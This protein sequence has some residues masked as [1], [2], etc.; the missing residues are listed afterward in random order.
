METPRAL[1][2]HQ[3]LYAQVRDLLLQRAAAGRN[4]FDRAPP[5]EV[6]GV[7][8]LA[9]GVSGLIAG[10]IAGHLGYASLGLYFAA[11]SVVMVLTTAATHDPRFQK[12]Q[13]RI[14]DPV[15][16]AS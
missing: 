3:R 13:D 10:F 11:A 15:R 14:P 9:A 2:Q 16:I 12:D 1:S 5:S 8:H 4:P 6:R 7:G